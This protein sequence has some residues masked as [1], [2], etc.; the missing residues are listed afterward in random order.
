MNRFLLTVK[1]YQLLALSIVWLLSCVKI[2]TRNVERYSMRTSETDH[3]SPG[4]VNF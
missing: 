3:R 1:N 4:I 2:S